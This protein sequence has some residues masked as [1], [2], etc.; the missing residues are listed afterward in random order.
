MQKWREAR[1]EADA[2]MDAPMGEKRIA[3]C[4]AFLQKY[5]DYPDSEWVQKSLI[6]ATIEKDKPHLDFAQL[7]GMLRRMA[8]GKPGNY[9]NMVL[10]GYYL[11]LGFP[12]EMMERVALQG[13]QALAREKADLASELDPRKRRANLLSLQAREVSARISEGRILLAKHDDTGA[14]RKLLEAEKTDSQSGMASLTL[15]NPEGTVAATLPSANA[16]SD[17][18]NL[19]LAVA[20]VRTGKRQEA[21]ARLDRVRNFL[22]F[23]DDLRTGTEA[24]RKEL[25]L[26]APDPRAI[27][28]DPKPS[29]DFHLKDL[30]GREVAL[31]DFRGRVVLVMFWAT[32]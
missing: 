23:D 31:S 27:R 2:A 1:E 24:L 20:Y 29:S 28:S 10:D 22:D 26:A 5:P 3:R 30:Q 9:S 4:E 17:R 6:D 13:R 25:G 12:P 21:I 14:I 8:K 18:L 11:N 16:V 32:W 15:V 7:D 19:A